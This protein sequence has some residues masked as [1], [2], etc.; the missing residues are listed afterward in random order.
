[1]NGLLLAAL[2]L[3]SLAVLGALFRLFAGP[4]ISD[5][6]AALDTIGILMLAMIAVLGMLLK[7]EAY[8]DIVLLI[9]IL[10]FIGTAAFARYI[11]RGI[12]ME[13]GGERDDR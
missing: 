5:R 12:V 2:I 4:S 13:S 10:T 8:L 3:L 9:G 11:E 6:I 7:T 1:M